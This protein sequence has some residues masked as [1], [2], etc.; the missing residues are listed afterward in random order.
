MSAVLI[1]RLQ[2]GSHHLHMDGAGHAVAGGGRSR[3]IPLEPFRSEW[4]FMVARE[5]KTGWKTQRMKERSFANMYTA[6]CRSGS[7]RYWKPD[8]VDYEDTQ[9]IGLAATRSEVNC[10]P[11]LRGERRRVSKGRRIQVPNPPAPGR[12][13]FVRFPW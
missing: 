5:G 9:M 7:W 10:R 3:R 6:V 11:W 1:D 2:L 12:G 4:A 13:G 8:L